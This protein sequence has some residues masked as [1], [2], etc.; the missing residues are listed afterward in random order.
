MGTRSTVIHPMIFLTLIGSLA[1]GCATPPAVEGLAAPRQQLYF[2]LELTQDGRKLGAPQLLGFEG[3]Q[4]VAEKRAPGAAEPEYR[5][6]LKPRESGTGYNVV[7]ELMLPS[8]KKVGEVALLH[9]EERSVQLGEA[10]LKLM[11]LRVDSPEFRALM[12][13]APAAGRGT[14]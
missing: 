14:I 13:L 8:G 2:A 6:V 4:V 3:R 12:A 1:I 11:L 10:E 5:L 9:G 7:L